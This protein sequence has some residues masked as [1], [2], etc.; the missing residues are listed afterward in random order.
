M[1]IYSFF[2]SAFGLG[3][4]SSFRMIVCINIKDAGGRS[5][6]ITRPRTRSGGIRLVARNPFGFERRKVRCD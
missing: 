5:H 2:R 6:C 3:V 1:R 4:E